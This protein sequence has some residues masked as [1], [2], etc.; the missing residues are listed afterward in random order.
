M[1]LMMLGM[2]IHLA[3]SGQQVAYIVYVWN[4]L[5]RN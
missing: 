4:E 5:P 3:E 1:I 2:Y